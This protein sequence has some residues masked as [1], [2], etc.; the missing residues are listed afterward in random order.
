ML[1]VENPLR[2]ES[3]KKVIKKTEAEAGSEN[4]LFIEEVLEEL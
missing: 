4:A 3:V 1:Q 2:G